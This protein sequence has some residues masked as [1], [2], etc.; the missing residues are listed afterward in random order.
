MNVLIFACSLNPQSRSAVLAASVAERLAA[1]GVAVEVVDL[2][3]VPLPMCDAGPAY[4]APEVGELSGKIAAAD[5]VLLAVPIYNY[6]VNAAAKNLIELTGKAWTGKVVGFL[7]AAGSK[8]SY[9]STMPLANSM[10]LDFRCLVLPRFVYATGDDFEASP[11]G[12]GEAL[13]G[14]IVERVSGLADEVRRVAGALKDAEASV[15]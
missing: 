3:D 6:D 4:A 7:C 11:D 12:G 15:G 10:M 9:M 2:R 8:V 13:T 14:P 5:A 1:D